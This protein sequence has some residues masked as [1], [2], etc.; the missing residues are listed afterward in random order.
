MT[1]S[2][3]GRATRTPRPAV[4]AAGLTATGKGMEASLSPRKFSCLLSPP[5]LCGGVQLCGGDECA[6]SSD[7]VDDSSRA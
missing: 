4:V 7:G 3:V 6:R 5:K 2:R 1:T